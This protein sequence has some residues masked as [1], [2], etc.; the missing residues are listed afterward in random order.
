MPV[1]SLAA[2]ACSCSMQAA[3][4]GRGRGRVQ[5][6]FQLDTETHNPTDVGMCAARQRYKLATIQTCNNTNMQ[7]YKLATIQTC[8]NTNLQQYKLATIQL[9]SH[10]DSTSHCCEPCGPLWLQCTVAVGTLVG[11]QVPAQGDE[12]A[13]GGV[14]QTPQQRMPQ[15]ATSARRGRW[16]RAACCRSSCSWRTFRWRRTSRSTIRQRRSYADTRRRQLRTSS[17]SRSSR[18]RAACS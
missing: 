5:V 12:R 9:G 10:S 8:N 14:R 2:Q 18:P 1:A 7:Q 4:H 3:R 6:R 11:A 15:R 13:G 16:R 17:G